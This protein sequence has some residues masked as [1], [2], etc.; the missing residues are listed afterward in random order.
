MDEEIEQINCLEH[1]DACATYICEHLAADPIQQWHSDFPTKEM[2]WPDAWCSRCEAEYAKEGEWNERNESKITVK[3]FCSHCY[4]SARSDSLGYIEGKALEQWR[5]FV[6]MCCTELQEK[7]SAIS[8]EYLLGKHKRYDWDQANG[9]LV[10]SNDGVPAVIAKI[11]FIGSFSTKSG[12]W[13]WA[14]ANFSLLENIRQQVE[15][16]RDFGVA[17]GFPW[18]TTAKWIAEEADGWDMSAIAAHILRA[19]GVYRSPHDSGSTFMVIRELR[20]V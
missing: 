1:G 18:L 20:N 8:K 13:L 14:W 2:P 11:D 3:V 15:M 17:Q 9:E 12:T 19:K 6:S 7:N 10:F 5:S 16:V 4:E